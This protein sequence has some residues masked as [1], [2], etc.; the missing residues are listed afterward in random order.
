M[1]KKSSTIKE[2]ENALD[3]LIDSPSITGHVVLLDGGAHL[4]PPKRDVS[5]EV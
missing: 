2:L 4:S 5:F 3:F 1:L